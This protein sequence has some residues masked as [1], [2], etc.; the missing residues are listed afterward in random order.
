MIKPL[1]Y[2]ISNLLYVLEFE[3]VSEASY[4]AQILER[5]YMLDLL[6]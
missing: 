6:A 4:L 5:L 1:D 2:I 3:D